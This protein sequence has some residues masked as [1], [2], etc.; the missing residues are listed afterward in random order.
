VNSRCSGAPSR[1]AEAHG[2][3]SVA[4]ERHLAGQL[5][6]D[7]GTSLSHDDGDEP[8]LDEQMTAAFRAFAADH[9]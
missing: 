4:T 6:Y 5:R 8:D 1:V 3:D 7:A 9:R 2:C